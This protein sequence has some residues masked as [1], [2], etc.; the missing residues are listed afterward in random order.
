M[1]KQS[2]HRRA[3]VLR[4]ALAAVEE[5]HDARL[6]TDLPGARE[7]FADELDLLGALALRW[8]TRLTGHL[9][10]EQVRT[11]RD[12]PGAAER[13]WVAAADEMPGL[14]AV[15]DHHREHPLDAAMATATAK[16]TAKEH[17]VLAVA[18]GR[19]GV[20]D[21]Q[22]ARVGA[23]VEQ[24]ARR[25]RL[26]GLATLAGRAAEDGP[27]VAMASYRPRRSLIERLRALVAA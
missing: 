3:E 23:H 25:R 15:L 5:R 8:H 7:T 10:R 12:L 17:A 27:A 14:R 4:R 22:A 20:G 2:A 18:A 26:A 21:P 16:A 11:P 1:S 9:E 6:P 19:A 13:A 24:A